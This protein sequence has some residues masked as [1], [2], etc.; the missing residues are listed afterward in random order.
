MAIGAFIPLAIFI[1]ILGS[2]GI[3]LMRLW[4]RTGELPEM[5]LGFGLVIV[6]MSMPLTA[7]GRAPAIAM[8]MAGRV[9]FSLGLIAI[10]VGIT[11]MVFFTFWVFR[12]GST[13]GVAGMVA[14][15]LALAAAVLYMSVQNF[16]GDSVQ[17]IKATMRPGTL[18]L[19]GVILLVFAWGGAESFRCFDLHRRRAALG[20]GDPVLANRFLLWGVASVTG[21]LL[22]IVVAGCVVAGMTIV[23]EPIPLAAIAASDLAP[24]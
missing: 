2:V 22:L 8:N 18:T 15:S 3:H 6:A 9:S 19:M 1:V 16:A 12:R 24:S 11:F 10:W 21:S 17:A 20:L 14:L 13:W 23:R 7:A 4:R 5:A